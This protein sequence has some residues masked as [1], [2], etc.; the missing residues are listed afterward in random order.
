MPALATF[1]YEV[2]RLPKKNIP[3][4]LIAYS[5]DD[6][7]NKRD[8]DNRLS[9]LTAKRVSSLSPFFR[10]FRDILTAEQVTALEYLEH[11]M[12][13]SEQA[14]NATS[15]YDGVPPP[16]TFGPK[17]YVDY[18][19]D[20]RTFVRQCRTAVQRDVG[21][22]HVWAWPLLE[23]AIL[24]QLTPQAAGDRYDRAIRGQMGQKKRKDKAVEIISLCAN[25]C[26]E[27]YNHRRRTRDEDNRK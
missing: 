13:V 17:T 4:R 10:Y 23:L 9:E 21:M 1:T 5:D 12:H 16:P 26:V 25:A 8:E 3:Q 2:S 24:D 18:A 22:K 11:Q 27:V 7:N 14:G 19:I 20:A 6:R 15:R